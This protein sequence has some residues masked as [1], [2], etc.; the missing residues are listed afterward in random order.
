MSDRKTGIEYWRSLEQLADSTAVSK[1]IEQ[2]FPGYDPKQM[3]S[4]PRRKFMQLAAASMALAGVTLTGCRRWPKEKVVASNVGQRGQMPGE[5]EYY[6]S[7]LERNGV[8]ESLLVTSIDG[9]PIKIEGNGH[10]PL[11][12]TYAGKDGSGQTFG[13]NRN[14]KLGGSDAFAQATLLDMYDPSRGSAILVRKVADDE[15]PTRG[16]WNEFVGAFGAAA[17]EGDGV[18][19]AVISE[20][21]SSPTF[22]ALKEAFLKKYPKAT[23][24]DYEPLSRDAELEGATLAFGKPVRAV[25]K[26][27]AAKTIVS[28]D[29]DLFGTHPAKIRYAADWAAGRR[30]VDGEKK[31]NRL[32]IVESMM[33]N[34]GSVADHRLPI[35]PSRLASIALAI[36]AKVGA[37]GG[38]E[39]ADLSEAEKKFVDAVS[40]D[41][42]SSGSSS[43]ITAG[44]Q[45]PAQVQALAH[46]INVKLGAVGTTVSYHDL[47]ASPSQIASLANVQKVLAGGTVKALLVIGGNPA[48]DA[49]A[50]IALASKIKDVPLSG[51]LSHYDDETSRQCRYHLPRSHSLE[52][53]GDARAYD[54]SVLLQQP[55]IEPLYNTRSAIELLAMLVA[56]EAVGSSTRIELGEKL[57]R[58]THKLDEVA[59]KTALHVG[60]IEGTSFPVAAGIALQNVSATTINSS[61]KFQ[62]RFQQSTQVY[63]GRFAN[64]GW[65]QETPDPLTKLVW[66]NAALV[67]KTDADELGVKHGQMLSIKR[68]DTTLTLPA[69]VLWGQPRGVIGLVVGYGRKAAG[70]VGNGVGFDV[71]PVRKSAELFYVFTDVDVS[72]AGGKHKLITTSDHQQMDWV[73][74]KAYTDRVGQK[75]ENGRILREGTIATYIKDSDFANHAPG[76]HRFPLLQLYDAPAGAKG[77]QRHEDAPVYFNTPHAWGMSIDMGVC[78]GCSACITACQAENNIPVVGKDMVEM[79]REMHWLRIDRYFKAKT[80]P[81]N[82]LGFEGNKTDDFENVDVVF[83]PMMCVQCEN[84]PCEQVCPVAATVHDTEGLNT[85]VYNRCI[86]TRYCSNNCPYKARRFNYMDWH[87]RDPRGGF[88]NSMWL[89]IPDQQQEESI[90]AVKKLVFNP[91]VTVRM[92]GVMEKCNYCT[93]RI[94]QATIPRKNEFAQGKREDYH[95]EDFDVVTACQQACPTQAIVFG[96]LQDKNSSVTKL[97]KIK[98]GY[99]VLEELNTRPR[100]KWLAKIRNP[101]ES[102]A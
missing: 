92:R 80:S 14:N 13:I 25:L 27:D 22:A 83:Q 71:Y 39:Q 18:G 74:Q 52:A 43:V 61:A 91:D 68:G 72:L 16:D 19:V 12:R 69:Y 66:D 42:L 56:D 47:P 76:Y 93:Q 9:R 89:K 44:P 96:D 35:K 34:T 30:S 63:D 45:A 31:M 10:H 60:F 48:Y 50:D 24:A 7:S 59:W 4:L 15:A 54:G 51:H 5:L 55:L 62:L 70:P 82:F 78:T 94:K 84:A 81:D 88:L 41:L 33:S 86:G 98:R 36:A 58:R 46:S 95:V 49:P 20:S 99:F 11:F 37:N 97:H 40:A 1:H 65:L 6:A 57:V 28:L 75:G 100:T 17:S 67:N 79:N 90:A 73:G 26:L 102:L 38:A 32:F 3:V 77:K 101:S 87:S 8:G 21:T 2:E 85:M 53:W 64:N 23:W 29:A